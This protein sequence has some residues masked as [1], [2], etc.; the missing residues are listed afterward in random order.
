MD[1]RKINGNLGDLHPTR[2]SGSPGRSTP[3]N[4]PECITVNNHLSF[5]RICIDLILQKEKKS[6]KRIVFQT[7]SFVIR[8]KTSSILRK[9]W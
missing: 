7:G 4:N 5:R 6:E 8:T 9:A 1:F 3:T 2:L